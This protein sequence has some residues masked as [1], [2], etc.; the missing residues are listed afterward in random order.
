MKATTLAWFFGEK[1]NHIS[2]VRAA[3]NPTSNV[4]LNVLHALLPN[5]I[6]RHTCDVEGFVRQRVA[7]VLL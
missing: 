1:S 2:I 5:I 3:F 6:N 7:I 4:T